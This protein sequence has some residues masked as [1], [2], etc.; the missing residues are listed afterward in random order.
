MIA[1]GVRPSMSFGGENRSREDEA[2][3]RPVVKRGNVQAL[4]RAILILKAA[5]A[6]SDG[7]TLTEIVRATGLA[8]STAHR[9]LTTLQQDRFVQFDPS[10]GR[11]R[12][13]LGAFTIGTAF[14]PARDIGRSARPFLRRLAE[15]CG[16][17]ANFA[18]L[19]DDMAVYLSQAPNREDVRTICKPG[20]RAFLHSSSLG[21]SMLALMPSGDVNRILESKGM[22]RFTERTIDTLSRM[23]EDLAEIRTL[24]YAVDDEENTLG[25]RCVAA[26]VTNEHGEPIAA[27]SV[28][29]PTARIP[30]TRVPNLGPLVRAIADELTRELGG[31]PLH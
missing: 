28:S 10:Q 30:R 7:L 1:Q 26:A 17:T 22:V 23:A 14:R 29:G 13:G 11:W 4:T 27:I 9:L 20:G 2:A 21:K 15:T 25:L 3:K 18:I 12:V 16:E 24:G 6:S 8:P 31:R 5:A 19:E